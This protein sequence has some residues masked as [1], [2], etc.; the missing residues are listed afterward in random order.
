MLKKHSII[1]AGHA[2]SVSLEP[3][4]WDELKQISDRDGISI[5]QIISMIDADRGGNLSS[6]IRIFIIND[7]RRRLSLSI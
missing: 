2:S 1:I 3:E 4:F 5:N 6:A 7:L